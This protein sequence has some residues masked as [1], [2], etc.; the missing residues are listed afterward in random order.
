MFTVSSCWSLVSILACHLGGAAGVALYRSLIWFILPTMGQPSNRAV[1]T[2]KDNSAKKV[3]VHTVSINKDK[4]VEVG[5]LQ[6]KSNP[7]LTSFCFR[8]RNQQS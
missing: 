5:L 4:I 7:V 6:S 2:V 1:V 3:F 8:Q